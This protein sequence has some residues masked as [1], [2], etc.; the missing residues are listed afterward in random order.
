[1]YIHAISKISILIFFLLMFFDADEKKAIMYVH[2]Y[3]YNVK[4][5]KT[6]R[7]S[8]SA[9]PGNLTNVT[10]AKLLRHN[11][12]RLMNHSSL[13]YLD[14]QYHISEVRGTGRLATH[15][16]IEANKMARYMK[17]YRDLTRDLAGDKR[18]TYR[19]MMYPIS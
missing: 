17:R 12:N 15:I 14:T 7:F 13:F 3:M 11:V 1:M 5:P 10:L 18:I 19:Q 4:I 6:V 2:M 8:L 16:I 9:T